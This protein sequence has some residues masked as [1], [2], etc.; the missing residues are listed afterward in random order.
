MMNLRGFT[1]LEM[2]VVL[3]LVGLIST[4]LFQGVSYILVMRSRIFVQLNDLRQGVIQE[5]WFRSSTAAIVTD[6]E[7]GEHI[8]KGD[9]RQ[10][11]G[12]TLAALD[13]A[14]GVPTVFSWQL[15]FDK[16]MTVLRYQKSQGDYWDVARWRGNQ[17]FF[18][19]RAREGEWHN[20]WP[21]SFGA[22]TPQ[23][24]RMILVQGQRRQ[25]SITWIVKLTEDDMTMIDYRNEGF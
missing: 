11:S 5:Y 14:V 6:Y 16:G 7:E 2:L 19:Y 3:V 22:D 20:Q 12:L 23:I 21:P 13:A 8:F 24:P 10:F 1:L 15:H 4:L 17:G 18:R 9:E 25:I